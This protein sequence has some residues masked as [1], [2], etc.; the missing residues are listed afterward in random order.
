MNHEIAVDCSPCLQ[1]QRPA[2][3]TAALKKQGKAGCEQAGIEFV[4]RTPER[5]PSLV[6]LQLILN[7][8]S[9]TLL[10]PHL[11]QLL[12]IAKTKAILG[13]GQKGLS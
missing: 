13:K 6:A 10:L 7:W 2:H 3:P 12:Q 4:S 11:G 1:V 5:L 9:R 8:R